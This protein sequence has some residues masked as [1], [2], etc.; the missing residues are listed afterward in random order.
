MP[1]LKDHLAEPLVEARL[2]TPKAAAVA[3]I[4]FAVLLS[5][6]LWLLRATVPTSVQDANAWVGTGAGRVSLAL[7]LI[8]F[9]GIA[10]MWFIGVLRD[11]LGQSEDRFFATV[12]LGSG[13]MFVG[14]MFVSASAL[15][16]I[17]VAYS[18][19]GGTALD[20][21]AF[22][23]ARAFAQDVMRIYAFKMAAVFMMITSTLAIRLG[24]INRWIV[25]AGYGCAAFLIIASGLINW[26]IF[27]FPAWV[28]LVSVHI[29]I[30]NFANPAPVILPD[31]A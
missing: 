6:S 14:M 29:L 10:L 22:A 28:L 18:S 27:V 26:A 20:A 30:E 1:N 11:R 15:G 16:G 5:A 23:F 8:P 4:L 24:F 25:V 21:H 9:A 13:L 3:G 19:S 31:S 7:N 17:L 12:L 2:K